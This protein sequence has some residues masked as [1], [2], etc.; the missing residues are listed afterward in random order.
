M[1]KK[2]AFICQPEYLRCHYE[3]DLNERYNVFEFRQLYSLSFEDYKSL[4]E[5]DA[6]VNIFFKA[7]CVPP[8]VFK[9]LRGK[10]IQISVEP[11]P[12]YINGKLICS[13]DMLQRE[14][15]L[16]LIKSMGIDYFFHYDNCSV[17]YLREKSFNVAGNFTLPIATGTYKPLECDKKWDLFFIGR[18]TEH[19]EKYL[20]HIKHHYNMLHI[21]HGIFGKDIVRFINQSKMAVNLHHENQPSFEPRVQMYMACRIPV[22]SEPLCPNDLF[23]P[24]K[25]YIEIRSPEDFVKKFEHF[26]HAEKEREDIAEN[27]YQLIKEK[28]SSKKV[29]PTL[30]ENI[31]NGSIKPV[32]HTEYLT[33]VKIEQGGLIKK[34][35]DMSSFL[36]WVLRGLGK[37]IKGKITFNE[38]IIAARVYLYEMISRKENER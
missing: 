25:H 13:E 24:D 20:G 21:A 18:S 38:G 36:K 14:K 10:V 33:P 27:G 23:I 29:F 12:K 1:K 31:L 5:F 34:T 19:R 11:I 9:S 8:E 37:L 17:R 16:E 3:H 30:I 6:D 35:K 22:M 26:L 4:L 7:E 32:T 15:G 28:L 2:I